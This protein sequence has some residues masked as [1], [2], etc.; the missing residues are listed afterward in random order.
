M[1]S[2]AS[3]I[4]QGRSLRR[5][6]LCLWS[7]ASRGGLLCLPCNKLDELDRAITRMMQEDGHI[8]F[9]EVAK[10]LKES[11]STVRFKYRR[12]VERGE[13]RGVV[14]PSTRGQ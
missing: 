2:E 8:S 4:S 6:R 9:A 5:S 7:K 11:E 13:I 10:S 1:R 12:L 14:A 3:S